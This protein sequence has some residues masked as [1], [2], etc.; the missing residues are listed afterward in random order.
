MARY[1]VSDIGYRVSGVG[2]QVLEASKLD[3]YFL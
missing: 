1:Q 2:Y 3:L